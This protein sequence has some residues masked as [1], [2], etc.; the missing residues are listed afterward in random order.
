MSHASTIVRFSDGL[1]LHG[2][3]NNTVDI[4]E[5]RLFA[6][7]DER[8]AMWRKQE[9]KDCTCGQASEKACVYEFAT[10]VHWEVTACRRCMVI[11]GPFHTDW[12]DLDGNEQI[13]DGPPDWYVPTAPTGESP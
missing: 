7:A 6:T 3:M 2:E 5:P 1:I 13:H 10:D 9:H 12:Y 11:V 8:D 4:L